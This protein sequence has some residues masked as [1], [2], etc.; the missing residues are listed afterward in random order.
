M[1]ALNVLVESTGGQANDILE[2]EIMANTISSIISGGPEEENA[3]LAT[4]GLKVTKAATD[5][6]EV[7]SLSI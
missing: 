1:T 7:I 3:K 4:N 6:Y 2:A 5:A